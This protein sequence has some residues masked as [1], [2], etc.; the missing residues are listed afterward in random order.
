MQMYQRMKGLTA[1]VF[2]PFDS[3]GQVNF[4]VIPAYA[5]RMIDAGMTGVFVCGT[6]GES[7]SLT[8]EERKSLA[9][10][11]VDA[12]RGRLP[13][14][15]H[16]GRHSLPE[17]VQ[18]ARHAR[19]I[20]ASAVAAI[21]PS[22]LKPASATDLVQFLIPIAAG[23]GEL[24]FYYYHIPALT[25]VR[26]SVPEFLSEGRTRI[27]TLAGVKFTHY[28]LMEM[29]ECLSLADGYFEI[30][31]GYDEILLPGLSL[32]VTAAIGSTFNYLPDVYLRLISA[33]EEGDLAS[34]RAWQMKSIE[35]VKIINRYG[36]AVR[37]GKAIMNLAGIECGA[38]RRPLA[39]FGDEEYKML[40]NDL[41]KT[42]FFD[43]S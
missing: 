31:N 26:V 11:W 30:L 27:P 6:S 17:A 4:S 14:I 9:G 3:S 42:G 38:C 1:A 15:V 22:F 13:V 41:Q 35:I 39:P 8:L 37:G 25:N 19:D 20:G 33:W 16:V 21:A 23:A 28:D 12:V 36:G 34:A 32:G 40:R 24:P 43:K 2:T 7:T 29:A 10:A 5:Q 18:L